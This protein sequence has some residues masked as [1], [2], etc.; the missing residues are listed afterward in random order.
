MMAGPTFEVI[1]CDLMMPEMTGM[2]LHR[3]LMRSSPELV[4]RVTFITGGAFTEAAAE[5]IRSLPG[6]VMEKPFAPNELRALVSDQIRRV[7]EA[8]L[9]R[10]RKDPLAARAT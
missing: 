5:F 8:V 6:K 3:A 9:R 1:L 7:D 2:E 4:D 10:E